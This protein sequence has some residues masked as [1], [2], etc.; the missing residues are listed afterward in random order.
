MKYKLIIGGII[1][2]ILLILYSGTTCDIIIRVIECSRESS[3]TTLELNSGLIYVLTTV[4]GLVSALVV[5]KL[6]IAV[7]GS[8][9]SVFRDLG[10]GQPKVVNVIVWCYLI[11]W[12]FTGLATLIAGVIL[13]PDICKTLSNF[14]TTWLGLAVAAGY[15][16]FNIDPR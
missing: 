12:T 7:P 8:D 5:S 4:G 2:W 13:F 1:A 14:G 15:S 9:P 16:Y 6:T 11:L 10:Q 3:C